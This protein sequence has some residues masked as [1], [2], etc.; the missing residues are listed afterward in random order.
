MEAAIF[1]GIK[2]S[3]PLQSL[4]MQQ[5]ELPLSNAT[6]KLNFSHSN[7]KNMKISRTNRPTNI[8]F[9]PAKLFNPNTFAK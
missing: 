9:P 1:F 8:D 6:K 4:T 7:L 3:H 5:M 2:V